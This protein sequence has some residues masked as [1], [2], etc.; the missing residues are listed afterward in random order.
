MSWL[1]VKD[2]MKRTSELER[3]KLKKTVLLIDVYKYTQVFKYNILMEKYAKILIPETSIKSPYIRTG[4]T[5]KN[6]IFVDQ[7][8]L[9]A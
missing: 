4:N 6:R 5:N 2:V 8:F 1:S 7:T 3:S 9:I